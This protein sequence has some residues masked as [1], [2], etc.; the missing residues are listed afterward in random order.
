MESNPRS[1]RPST[2]KTGKNVKYVSQKMCIDHHLIVGMIVN[3]S[4]I[5]CKRVWTIIMEDLCKNGFEIAE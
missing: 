3:E 5:N 1:W 4:N 2:S